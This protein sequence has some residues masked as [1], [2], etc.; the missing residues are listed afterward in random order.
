MRMSTVLASLLIVFASVGCAGSDRDRAWVLSRL[1]DRGMTTAG[2]ERVDA[3]IAGE[4][5][6]TDVSAVAL[7]RSPR[8]QAELARIDSARADL[9]EAGRIANPQL[10]LAGPFGPISALALILVPLESLW[11]LPSRTET[12]TRALESTAE[13]VVQTGLDVA[14]DA[15]LAHVEVLLAQDRV[16]LRRSLLELNTEFAR[17]TEVRA[18]LGETTPAEA[19]LARAEERTAADALQAGETAIEMTFARLREQLGLRSE[20]AIFA[21]A[22]R[23]DPIEPPSASELLRAARASRPDVRGAELAI[24]MA[25]ARAGWERTRILTLS[26][27]VEAQW[28]APDRLG[29]RVGIR[30]ELPIFGANPGGIG[31]ADAE[32]LRLTA[33]LEMVRLRVTT[34]VIESR[35]RLHQSRASLATYRAEVLPALDEALRVATR[36]F[37]IGE[38]TYLVVLDALRRVA[39]ARLLEL[40]LLAESRRAEAE[41]E[42]AIGA[43]LEPL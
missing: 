35:A 41:L 19:A 17:I 29:V 8:F 14:R 38:D 2:G 1:E 20:D 6:E 12:A 27:Q 23:H 18:R 4:L 37:E 7:A 9:D 39:S 22:Y 33:L 40:D 31:R 28:M 43:R 42:R 5:D 26:A 36:T 11:Q 16:A 34:E 24:E 10:T 25:A 32:V 13:T 3:P 15:R 21:V 30:T